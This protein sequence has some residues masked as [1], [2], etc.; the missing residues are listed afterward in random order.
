MAIFSK[1]TE[2]S[3]TS[4]KPTPRSS[5]SAGEGALS[6]IAA[7]MRIKGDIDTDGVIRIEGHVEGS[8]RAGRQVL[9]GRQGEIHG[10]ISTR[11]AVVGGHVHGAITATERVEVQSTSSVSGDINTKS[12]SVAEGG[13]IDGVVRI[14]E[15]APETPQRRHDDHPT[16]KAE[17]GVTPVAVVR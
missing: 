11:E 8:I 10:D 17:H 13:K 16:R 7:G 1:D 14:A 12:L 9:I 2:S 6:I 3:D 15:V 4:T 5:S